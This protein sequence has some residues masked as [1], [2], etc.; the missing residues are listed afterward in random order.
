MQYYQ[1]FQ[2]VV[3][4]LKE[5]AQLFDQQLYNDYLQIFKHLPPQNDF[6]FTHI[7]MEYISDFNI[8]GI[9]FYQKQKYYPGFFVQRSNDVLVVTDV[10]DDLQFVIGDEITL[11]SHD[12]IL[13]LSERYKKHF[14]EKHNE[15]QDWSFIL[16]KQKEVKV[17]RGDTCYSF[18]LGQYL[19]PQSQLRKVERE[20]LNYQVFTIYNLDEL[21]FDQVADMSLQPLI[22]D[23]RH[24]F[25]TKAISTQLLSKVHE[26]I[27]QHTIFIIQSQFTCGTAE[28][29]IEVLNKS[30]QVVT[31]G[32]PSFGM[33]T[34][35]VHLTVDHFHLE[36]PLNEGEPIVPDI[37]LNALYTNKDNCMLEIINRLKTI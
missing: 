15:Y 33:G 30:D 19:Y 22:L 25:G 10:I 34:E 7:M 13:E 5:K 31:L 11:M 21:D 12:S 32:Q 6:T 28:K 27:K 18:E 1:I 26:I 37:E 3:A 4:T 14:Y 2:Q 36:L 35:F 23:L 17:K 24:A 20:T 29:L 8:P 9:Y 16:Q